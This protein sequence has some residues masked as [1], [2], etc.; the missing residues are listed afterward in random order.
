MALITQSFAEHYAELVNRV[1][2]H[3]ELLLDVQRREVGE[4][5]A[6]EEKCQ[7]AFHDVLHVAAV[8]ISDKKSLG[9]AALAHRNRFELALYQ[10]KTA[11]WFPATPPR[12][13]ALPTGRLLRAF[14]HAAFAELCQEERELR[15]WLYGVER[16]LR[17]H[18]EE[19][20]GRAWFFLNL[21]GETAARESLSRQ[22]LQYEEDE[23]FSSVKQCFFRAVPAEY[24]RFVVIA[25]YGQTVRAVE[26]AKDLSFEE[27]EEEARAGLMEEEETS[28][29]S[30]FQYLQDMYDLQIF[31]LNHREVT[32]RYELEEEECNSLFPLVAQCC[33]EDFGIVFYHVPALALHFSSS[34]PCMRALCLTQLQEAPRRTAA[35]KAR[36]SW[37][38]AQ[39]L[40]SMGREEEL[41]EEGTTERQQG[42]GVS[43][44]SPDSAP[45]PAVD[46]VDLPVCEQSA[47]VTPAEETP[48]AEDARLHVPD[49]YEETQ[50]HSP[51]IDGG[52][53]A[54]AMLNDVFASR[55]N[56][57]S[58]LILAPQRPPRTLLVAEELSIGHLSSKSPQERKLPKRA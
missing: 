12:Q 25:R 21:I 45:S 48:K 41:E 19:A 36:F 18:I 4:R 3:T 7:T 49:A 43:N 13:V 53:E 56:N 24:Y 51:V 20:C 42:N 11:V 8:M 10:K 58:E 22:R 35:T 16:R 2:T 34:F 40:A 9:K 38:P 37:V 39:L 5:K 54:K 30:A 26:A 32:S 27:I 29:R 47:P 50:M 44:D 31:A 17:E 52:E 14:P 1:P 33:R 15:Q 6:L 57:N 28:R 23:A 46:A 55:S